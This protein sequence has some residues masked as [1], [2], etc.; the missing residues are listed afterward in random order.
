MVAHLHDAGLELIL[1]VVY[2]TPRK[3]ATSWVRPCACAASTTPRT[4]A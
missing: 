4:T 3:A 1:D 2:N